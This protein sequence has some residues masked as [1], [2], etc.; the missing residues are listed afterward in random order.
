MMYEAILYGIISGA[1]TALLG[2]AKSHTVESFDG[3]KALKTLVIGAFIGLVA[4][5]YN[6]D[7]TTAEQWL[8][9]IGAITVVQYVL[10]AI[11]RKILRRDEV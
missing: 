6:I 2:Y 3:T 10:R 4:A 9:S 7:F 5:Y 1:I 8:G 11:A